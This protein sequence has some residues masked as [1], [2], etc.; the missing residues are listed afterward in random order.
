M[1]FAKTKKL[2]FDYIERNENEEIEK[3]TTAL[4][5]VDLDIEEG[6]FIAILGKNG[7]GKSTLAR[8]LNAL[9]QPTQGSVFINGKD[10]TEQDKILAIRKEVSM[11][12]QNPDNQIV[13][14]TVEEDVAF[15]LENLAVESKQI[16]EK[17]DKALDNMQLSEYAKTA[18]NR[19]SGGQKQRVALAGVLAMNTK[20]IVLDEPTAML[21]PQ[22]RME[23]M[24]AITYLNK[25]K[26]ITIIFITHNIEEA[27]KADKIYVMKEGKIVLSGAPDM[28]LSK[29]EMMEE[30]GLSLP[31]AVRF[32]KMLRI[33]TKI[34][35]ENDLV[36]YF[37]QEKDKNSILNRLRALEGNEKVKVQKNESKA[38]DPSLGLYFDK[39]SF[40]Y[41]AGTTFEKKAVENI[42]LSI[43]PGEKIALIGQSGSG[44][45]TLFQLMNGL[46]QPQE[47]AIYYHGEDISAK[48]YPIRELRCKV[49]LTFQ[50][51]EKQFFMDTV[52][53]EVAFG[54]NNLGISKIEAQKRAY[55]A[56]EIMGLSSDLYDISPLHL[57]G[58]QKR[59]VAIASILAMK[60]EV[61]LLDEPTAGLDAVAKKQLFEKL[62][63]IHEKWRKTIIISSHNMDDIA[64]FADK[65]M[66]MKQGKLVYFGD[67]KAFFTN[68]D[69]VK[70]CGLKSTFCVELNHKLQ[71]YGLQLPKGIVSMKD[72]QKWKDEL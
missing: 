15:G 61:L 70:E 13:G 21:D 69:L 49:G 8:H 38:I 32:A 9:L 24:E 67:T 46:L 51:P 25:K 7:S 16:R 4:D 43:V 62:D 59:A 11:V 3:I 60:P 12:F 36:R 68:M 5:E 56:I 72:L 47:G 54:P 28:I 30:L 48:N 58:G 41:Q 29:S 53:D 65:V 50:Y 71:E 64:N 45:S 26:H 1:L 66:V 57:S 22:G 35:E 10:T 2:T 19:L 34:L 55:D 17:V 27:M 20:C 37:Y 18:P 52:Y 33:E 14:V 23:V 63:M 40:S 42:S 6:E 44:K 39:V 31:Y